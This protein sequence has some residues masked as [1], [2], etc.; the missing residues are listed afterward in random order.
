MAGIKYNEAE[1]IKNAV[2]KIIAVLEM[3][4]VNPDRVFCIRSLGTSSSNII[5]RCHALPKILQQVLEI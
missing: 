5:A 2:R 4:H 3:D 1:D